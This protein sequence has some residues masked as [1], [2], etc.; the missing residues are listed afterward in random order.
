M[1]F[2][3]C[4]DS[5]RTDHLE[6]KVSMLQREIRRLGCLINTMQADIETMHAVVCSTHL[7][8]PTRMTGDDSNKKFMPSFDDVPAGPAKHFAH[9]NSIPPASSR[10]GSGVRAVPTIK[11]SGP[12]DLCVL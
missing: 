12:L 8:Q 6:E 4:G 5:G 11:P 9:R 10:F 3:W 1:R 7:A 2:V